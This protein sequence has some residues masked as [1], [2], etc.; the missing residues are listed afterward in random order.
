MRAPMSRPP[1]DDRRPGTFSAMTHS[2]CV[3]PMRRWNSHQRAERVPEPDCI[4]ARAPAVDKSWHGKPPTRTPPS[5]PAKPTDRRSSP[6]TSLTSSNRVVCGKW[7]ARTPR[8][9]LSIST[10]AT[11]GIPA[12]WNANSKPPM[13]ANRDTTFFTWPTSSPTPRPRP[14]S[15]SRT[16]WWPSP[17][18]P[19]GRP[20]QPGGPGPAARP[21]HG[22]ASTARPPVSPACG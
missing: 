4:P 16:G 1:R 13:P 10:L 7:W 2:G 6:V 9:C 5:G 12:R 19:P 11:V 21:R 17:P 3:S 15:G 18:A 20:A 8:A 14:Q 22:P